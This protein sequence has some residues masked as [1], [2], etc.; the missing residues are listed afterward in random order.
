M[1]SDLDNNVRFNTDPGVDDD[2]SSNKYRLDCRQI[3]QSQRSIQPFRFVQNTVN[4]ILPLLPQIQP[5]KAPS[6]HFAQIFDK[7]DSER[8]IRTSLTLPKINTLN[9]RNN[10][11]NEKGSPTLSPSDTSNNSTSSPKFYTES[12]NLKYNAGIDRV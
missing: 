6:P 12:N 3:L 8:I 9:T 10:S 1:R 5:S 11:I 4:E 7:T 2:Y